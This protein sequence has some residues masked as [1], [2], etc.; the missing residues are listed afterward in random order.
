MLRA[1][2]IYKEQSYD[3]ESLLN[4]LA[5]IYNDQL[6][7][8]LK[9]NQ[10]NLEKVSADKV[11][12]FF[13]FLLDRISFCDDSSF[14]EQVFITLMEV[15]R[16]QLTSSDFTF[17][18]LIELIKFIKL[19][20]LITNNNNCQ[21]KM[22]NFFSLKLVE[23]KR[24][25]VSDESKLDIL[26]DNLPRF[27]RIHMTSS[28]KQTQK[29]YWKRIED[30]RDN[31]EMNDYPKYTY[32]SI[33]QLLLTIVDGKEL[34]TQLDNLKEEIKKNN[35]DT[36]NVIKFLKSLFPIIF[37]R[38][39]ISTMQNIFMTLIEILNTQLAS[40]PKSFFP[41]LIHL[42]KEIHELAPK[43]TPIFPYI[44]S[45]ELLKRMKHIVCD[46]KQFNEILNEY[47][48]SGQEIIRKIQFSNLTINNNLAVAKNNSSIFCKNNASSI[49][50]TNITGYKKIP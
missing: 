17:D 13:K 46:E 20:T 49:I 4:S 43:N 10:H 28:I 8:W 26:I 22:Q 50:S 7:Q 40:T 34:I 29:E 3:A 11:N 37:Y 2:S 24:D 5:E 16:K 32:H 14:M 21:E 41:D 1:D 35:K 44:F 47:N 6:I 33:P 25:V 36:E 9:V 18:N 48:K 45:V 42:V 15:F 39:D 12:T 31:L 23:I 30:Q 27:S 19:I 38:K